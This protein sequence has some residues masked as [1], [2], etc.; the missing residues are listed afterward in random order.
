MFREIILPIFRSTRLCVTAYGVMHPPRCCRPKAICKTLHQNFATVQ[1]IFLLL[2]SPSSSFSA[3]PFAVRGG[4]RRTSL[5]NLPFILSIVAYPPLTT[6]ISI[7]KI[8]FDSQII[9]CVFC[10][11]TIVILFCDHQFYCHCFNILW[12]VPV[13]GS[14]TV[15]PAS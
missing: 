9:S 15:S 10:S 7:P 8:I 6:H 4:V 12:P 13:N 5:Q 2:P 14:K 1:N 3:M 11:I